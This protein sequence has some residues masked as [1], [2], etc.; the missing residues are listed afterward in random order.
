MGT[1]TAAAAKGRNVGRKPPGAP[2]EG[3]GGSTDK[4]VG[5]KQETFPQ[6]F[7]QKPQEL[8]ISGTP[9]VLAT[10]QLPE[11]PGMAVS[12]ARMVEP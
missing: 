7:P 8:C 9:H 11:A 10:P 4:G 3:H 1:P 2:R 6:V 12:G 5:G